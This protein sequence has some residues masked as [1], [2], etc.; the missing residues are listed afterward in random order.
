MKDYMRQHK[1][2]DLKLIKYHNQNR[3]MNIK[4]I[5]KMFRKMKMTI[6]MMT[7]PKR[8]DLLNNP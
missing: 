8:F 6:K 1:K 4:I 7:A 2:L 5:N 3:I